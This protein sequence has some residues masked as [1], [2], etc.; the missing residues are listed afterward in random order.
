L[1]KVASGLL[2][3]SVEGESIQVFIV[4]P[5]G[6]YFDQ[7]EWGV[8]SIPKGLL[9]EG[10][11]VESAA[12]R[13]FFEEVGVLPP[14]GPYLDLGE[15]RLR[16]GKVVRI[17]AFEAER[18]LAF[19]ESNEFELEWPRHSGV[20]HHFPEVDRGGWFDLDGAK[21]RLLESQRDFLDRLVTKIS[22]TQATRS[23]EQ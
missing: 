15:V 8:W 6:P 11:D 5:G 13:E 9:D 20:L 18:D 16:S 22:K 17:F 21:A 23:V 14:D 2:P 1:T 4:H 3:F 12:R 7:Q 19:I 10:E